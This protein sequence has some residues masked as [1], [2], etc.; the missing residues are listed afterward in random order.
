MT[1]E[2]KRGP[3]RPPKPK[4]VPRPVNLDEHKAMQAA[5][6]DIMVAGNT[7]DARLS[8]EARKRIDA[9]LDKVQGK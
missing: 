5:W 2:K 4:T 3:G 7:K 8:D 6:K 1:E 9:L